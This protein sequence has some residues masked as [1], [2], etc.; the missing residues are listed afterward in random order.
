MVKSKGERKIWKISK[1]LI[2]HNFG[3]LDIL[4]P[5]KFERSFRVEI[6]KVSFV[7]GFS[8]LL[9]TKLVVLNENEALDFTKFLK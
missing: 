2:H 6:R 3:Y 9:R 1:F 8:S 4:E 7:V 5:L